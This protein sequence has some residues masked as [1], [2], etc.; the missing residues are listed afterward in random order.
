MSS[1]SAVDL[2]DLNP[3]QRE[4]VLVGDGPA[5]VLA[6]AGS[7]KTRVVTRRIARLVAE[8]VPARSIVAVTFTNKA[9]A[10]MRERAAQLVPARQAH[11]LRVT[12]F[13][14]F[15]L[16][17]L[18]S[19][20][21]ALGF[22]GGRFAVFDQADCLGTL[23]ELLRTVD[24]GKRFDLAALLGRISV[25]KNAFE[26]PASWVV[27][28]GDEYDDLAREL[29]PRYE[30]ALRAQCA[31]DFDDLV[32]ES[33]RLLRTRDDVRGRVQAKI[34][35]LLVDEYQD[36]NA[37][38][39][40]L[41]R[42]LV[43]PHKSVM[44]V[45]DDDQA[46]YG[47][48]GAEVR[49]ILDFSEHFP[50]ARVIKLEENYRSR[51]SIC[52]VANAVLAASQG[53]RHG[54]VLR[55]VRDAGDKVEVVVVPDPEVEAT[56]VAASIADALA[57][58]PTLRRRDV[59]VLY[60]SNAQAEPLEHAL[61]ERG[62]RH[63]VLGGQ[64]FY[65]RK[66]V[67]DLL[68]YLKV[69]L[70]P[71]DELSLRRIVNY[72]S[73]GIGEVALHKLS[74]VATARDLSLSAAIERAQTIEDLPGAALAGCESLV[75]VLAKTRAALESGEPSSAVARDLAERIQL[76]EDVLEASP[77]EA[78]ARR[79]GN[80]EAILNVLAKRDARG[81]K[82]LAA[83]QA[84]LRLLTLASDPAE[85]EDDVITLATMHGAKGLEFRLVH[86]L[87]VEEGYLPHTRT[88][89]PKATAV[90]PTDVEEE[91]RLF[92]V[93]V[94]R[95]KDRLVLSRCKA[96]PMR[97]KPVPRTVSR[98]LQAVPEDL[99]AEREVSRLGPNLASM[100]EGAAGLLSA[101]EGLA[102]PSAPRLRRP[103]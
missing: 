29:F 92:Y 85:E 38:Q 102:A 4:A 51:G 89:D 59:A 6:G 71:G 44:V 83:V 77:G 99:L 56:M 54:K 69:A 67:K 33:V 40:E 53:R 42:L 97:G 19:E 94:T 15:G 79:W 2:S 68:A 22:R 80:V 84:F 98:F 66:E 87:G 72:P 76:R 90:V 13:H 58:D 52:A 82:D 25:A 63:R 11:E 32:T 31:V 91:R 18:A 73:R 64:K 10:E 12:T 47:W 61:R 46:I 81:P 48:R 41:V 55:P 62:L 23:R 30:A 35:Y 5:L 101:L 14:S 39:L 74:M 21:R 43:E 8:G 45:G 17:L 78:G 88:T 75:Q 37:A 28:E 26:T 36:T 70:D 9:A 20:V 65:E 93:A 96:R 49:N 50:G 34:R 24:A 7:G 100:A 86:V 27:R 95:A 16:D 103:R 60:R 1:A 57:A 3:S